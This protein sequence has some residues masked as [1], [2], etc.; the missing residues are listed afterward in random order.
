M[1]SD[2]FYLKMVCVGYILKSIEDQKK[3]DFETVNKAIKIANKFIY[4]QL[5]ALDTLYNYS[6]CYVGNRNFYKYIYINY[7]PIII[8]DL[9]DGFIKK[10]S[11]KC[12]VD[13]DTAYSIENDIY[14][15]VIHQTHII[16]EKLFRIK[17]TSKCLE[18]LTNIK[19]HNK[20]DIEK[21]IEDFHEEEINEVR[22]KFENKPKNEFLD[23]SKMYKCR[24][25]GLNETIVTHKQVR[26]GDE[27]TDTFIYCINCKKTYKL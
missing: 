21:K 22:D 8:W 19:Y 2:E 4:H 16:D 11:N 17:Y 18:Y 9:S 20:F 3:L 15:Y 23:V 13:L 26:A 14:K 10:L 12:G 6:K 5:P 7:R 24:N 27:M 1:I 25:C